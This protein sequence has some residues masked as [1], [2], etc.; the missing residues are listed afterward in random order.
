MFE[1]RQSRLRRALG[2][3]R[4]T[5]VWDF[6]LYDLRCPYFAR[7]LCIHL[8][9][10]HEARFDLAR[11]PRVLSGQTEL[12]QALL[13]FARVGVYAVGA[14]LLD[15]VAVEAACA[16]GN[17]RGFHSA[18]GQYIPDAVESLHPSKALVITGFRAA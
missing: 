10:I 7:V 4:R 12:L 6:R 14:G 15:F 13:E 16:K 18:T 11:L 8:S 2:I 3:E 17:D 1:V 5:D 9:R